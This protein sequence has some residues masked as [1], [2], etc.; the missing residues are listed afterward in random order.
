MT[1]VTLEKVYAEVK[2]LRKKL[3]SIEK[4]VDS[5]AVSLIP[6][7]EISEEEMKELE[8][9]KEEALKGE[10][11]SLEEVMKKHGVKRRA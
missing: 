1:E 5:L 3:K 8:T 9:L 6:E 10:C 7:E 4:K 2:Q 11:V